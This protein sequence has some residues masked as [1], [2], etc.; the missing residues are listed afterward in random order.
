MN[1]VKTYLEKSSIQGI[2]LFAAEL[3]EKGTIVWELTQIDRVF[4]YAEVERMKQPYKDHVLKYGYTSKGKYILCGDNGIFY[5]HSNSPN[6]E[7]LGEF[8]IANR[9]IQIGEELTCDYFKINDDHSRE[10]FRLLKP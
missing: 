6:T 8:E 2:G 9:D 10:I 1:T 3:I 5:N 7:S 4:T